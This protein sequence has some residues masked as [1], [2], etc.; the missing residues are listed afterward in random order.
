MYKLITLYILLFSISLK[1]H[2]C[3]DRVFN[4]A[5]TE[6]SK[7]IDFI[8]Q[9]VDLCK[10]NLVVDSSL[11]DKILKKRLNKIYIR[12]KTLEEVLDIILY[13]NNIFHSLSKDILRI[14]YVKTETYHI[15]YIASNR[16]GETSTEISVGGDDSSTSSGGG[17][18]SNVGTKIETTTTFDNFWESLKKEIDEI[19]TR[20]EDDYKADSPILNEKG[21]LITVSG[22]LNQ[23]K[24]VERYLKSLEEK[25]KKQVLIDVNILSVSLNKSNLTGINWSDFYNVI[26][27]GGGTPIPDIPSSA[28]TTASVEQILSFLKQQGHVTSI[29]NP[30]IVALN[31][32]PAL[33]S[34]G[35][36]YFYSI[37]ETQVVESD[38]GNSNTLNSTKIESVF[39]GILLDITAE[40]SKDNKIT[41]N[42]NPSISQT[43]QTISSEAKRSIPPDLTKK[44]LS[45][46]IT[47]EDG[48]RIVL[49]GLITRSS[50]KEKSVVPLLGHLPIFGAFFRSEKNIYVSEELIIIITPH[51]LESGGADIEKKYKLIKDSAN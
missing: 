39:A 15:D 49:G 19:L 9:I 50:T 41:L 37:E 1:A 40:I 31:N 8:D 47:T 13:E 25:L 14:S 28:I 22:T 32:Q 30:K 16:K 27:S 42:V 24:R 43:V 23:L 4:I 35:N 3:E 46:V 38:A 44:Q 33:I 12:E 10:L 48:K 36:E 6:R 26:S 45:S 17:S 20:P 2:S 5:S 51:I 21:G 11:D 29:S 18:T 34:V 7:V